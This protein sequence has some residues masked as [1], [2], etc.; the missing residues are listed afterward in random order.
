MIKREDIR[1]ELYQEI[2]EA[3]KHHDHEIVMDGETY[4]WKR[5]DGIRFLVDNM[6]LND[7]VDLLMRLGYDKNSEIFRKLYRNMGY[8]LYGY[9]EVFY[10]ETNNPRS[11]EYIDMSKC[12]YR[13][14]RISF[15]VD[16]SFTS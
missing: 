6:D 3:E 14:D 13:E 4:R 16:D 10:W 2:F 9:W 12:R 1:E 7:L 11:K 15:L 8:S 5:N